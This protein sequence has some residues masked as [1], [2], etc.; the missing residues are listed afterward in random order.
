[1]FVIEK[2]IPIPERVFPPLENFSQMEEMEIGDSI[3]LTE[4]AGSAYVTLEEIA[5]FVVGQFNRQHKDDGPEGKNWTYREV[6]Y[7]VRVWRVR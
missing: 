3:L 7:G 6:G 4:L 2:N 5:S 1:M